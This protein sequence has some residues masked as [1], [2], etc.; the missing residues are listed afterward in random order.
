MDSDSG[1]L[2]TA[3]LHVL[4]AAWTSLPVARQKDASRIAN[5]AQFELKDRK[6]RTV[7]T[8]VITGGEKRRFAIRN[9]RGD[10]AM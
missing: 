3:R 6:E 9:P 1:H 10:S 4:S 8:A 7:S 2:P 5:L